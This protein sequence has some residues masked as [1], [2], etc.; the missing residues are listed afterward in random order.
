M[1]DRSPPA[2]LKT[3]EIFPSGTGPEAD[4]VAYPTALRPSVST[5]EKAGDRIGRYQLIEELGEGGFGVVWRAEQ[6]EPVRREVALKVIKPGMDSRE[7]IARFESERQALAM[8][9]HPNI[10]HM[11]EGG[12]TELGRPYFAM[13]F[14]KGE[15]ITHVCDK[16]GLGLEARLGIFIDVCSGVQHAHQKAII[17]RDLKPSN[18]L[19]MENDGTFVPKVIDFGVAKALG[20]KLTEHTLFTMAGVSVGTPQYMSPEQAGL[21]GQDVDT[22]SD[23]YSLGVILYEL[24]T[25]TTPLRREEVCKMR[26]SDLEQWIREKDPERPS[27]RIQKLDEQTRI[28]LAQCR[29]V[30][31]T[32]LQRTL[33]GELDWI[34][35]RSLEKDR[36]RRY[37][38]V[39]ALIQDLKRH[40]EGRVV[41]AGPPSARYRIGKLVSRHRG[42]VAAA[43]CVLV[44]LV[45]G[46][47]VAA[48]RYSE[49]KKA[50]LF[51]EQSRAEAL[52]A[53]DS[54]EG[55]VNEAIYG[56]REKLVALGRAE[57]LEGVVKAAEGYYD[58]LPARL[59]ND[60]TQRHLGSLALN[61]SIIALALGRDAEAEKYTGECLR[62][63][64]ALASAYPEREDLQK[65]ACFAMLSLGYLYTERN[66]QTSLIKIADAVVARA[67][68]WLRKHPDTIWA[69]Y[70]QVVGH[71]LVAQALVR[72][73]G[74]AAE[75][76][77]RFQKAAQIARRM[78]EI[79]GDDPQVFE[80]EGMIHYGNAK[81]AEKLKQM[82]LALAEFRASMAAFARVEELGSGSALQQELYLGAMHQVGSIL[83]ERGKRLKRDGEMK[84]GQGMMR[85]V[86]ESRKKLLVVEPGRA[87][88]WRDLASS[89]YS[90]SQMAADAGNA[91]EQLASRE[92]EL[93]CR[94]EAV[95]RS[96]RRPLL[97]QERGGSQN[98]LAALLLKLGHP[99]TQ[100]VIDL[101]LQ[102]LEELRTA[103]EMGGFRLASA[104]YQS[105]DSAQRLIDLAQ[106]DTE[107]G[108]AWMQ[109]ARATL[110]PIATRVEGTD[111]MTSLVM[112]LTA[113]QK[114]LRAQGRLAEADAAQAKLQS[115]LTGDASPK[116]QHDYARGVIEGLTRELEKLYQLP[117]AQQQEL[118]T[119]GAETL[120][121]VAPSVTG[122]L[123]K[124]PLNLSY[125]ETHGMHWRAQAMVLQAQG[126]LR[127]AV[128]AC[129]KAIAD[130]DQK[131][132][133]VL[134]STC[135]TR[136]ADMLMQL[137]DHVAARAH[138]SRLVDAMVA[139][140]A[141][142]PASIDEQQNLGNAWLKMALVQRKLK[143]AAGTT[144]AFTK[145]LEIL[146]KAGRARSGNLSNGWN[147]ARGQV[148]LADHLV[149]CGKVDT[150]LEIVRP[151]L[152]AVVTLADAEPSADRIT[153]VVGSMSYLLGRLRNANRPIEAT[154]LVRVMLQVREKALKI[155]G[156]ASDTRHHPSQLRISLA[157]LL[158]QQG[159]VTEADAEIQVALA[160]GSAPEDPAILAE[161]Y[162]SVRYLRDTQRRYEECEQAARQA[163]DLATRANLGW[164]RLQF[165]N[166]L[167]SAL[168]R[169][170]KASEAIQL[171]QK[172]WDEAQALT[173]PGE[174]S[175]LKT[176]LAHRMADAFHERHI[177]GVDASP[178]ATA[179]MW[180]LRK[181]ETQPADKQTNEGN[182]SSAIMAWRGWMLQVAEDG[183]KEE[184]LRQGT[185]LLKLAAQ[186][187]TPSLQSRLALG[188]LC[189]PLEGDALK[190]AVA[191]AIQAH[192]TDAKDELIRVTHA[193]ALL[194]SGQPEACLE[195][196]KSGLNSGNHSFWIC[197]HALSALAHHQLAHTAE[198]E[199]ELKL[200]ESLPEEKRRYLGSPTHPDA[201]LARLLL[202][203]A[204]GIS[205]SRALPQ[206]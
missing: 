198:V 158:S 133:L 205:S 168:I 180:V 194:R 199:A 124:E 184:H 108:L 116:M 9:D 196:V 130:L 162:S 111:L 173:F 197:F 2:D 41:E 32:R 131:S 45:A 61:R 164:R 183:R 63:T 46:L 187:T 47:G 13:E 110:E 80:V 165:A 54:A 174:P 122:A 166:D 92:E 42:A 141:A 94:H 95:L 93:R 97:Y 66:D 119:R 140:C 150:A 148:D 147:L 59:K 172:A 21:H 34:V 195:A 33:R 69:M 188:C 55:L 29:K 74:Q 136:A 3:P 139:R 77:S 89:H 145:G 135:H 86:A 206:Q 109:K 146:Q 169:T 82:D 144:A 115:I 192:A 137:N 178:D 23:V 203:E 20:H 181:A 170:G 102:S 67:D 121:A 177:K 151:A 40:M 51:A 96:P 128:A 30:D 201:S 106:R 64:E 163:V 189:M 71:N 22:R 8:M 149:E 117:P 160:P 157:A 35:M 85:Q 91:A 84:Q 78:R 56:L 143:D 120:A 182:F 7:I 104:G 113:E 76:F 142:S 70:Y 114:S 11:L 134:I 58:T 129:E 138:V 90:L 81:V 155:P 39:N 72:G 202:K 62:L 10:A 36:G 43:A 4:T 27:T 28:R 153:S 118:A 18:I 99:D 107:H 175:R 73:M 1:D 112:L 31:G 191:L 127:E 49:E 50:R 88:W 38:T 87:E 126:K 26:M 132:H 37:Q 167:C 101:T 185:A 193:L 154:Q 52:A 60:E 75:G 204:Q 12:T 6:R 152:E 17:H 186:C 68:A 179:N 19:V 200:L 103:L 159:L 125:R 98:G 15:P 53:R 156:P 16:R 44:A 24:L 48:W 176:D 83:Y 105:R 171:G 57:L 100:R 14:V 25:G 161:V 65:E 5:A 123:G 79:K 190:P